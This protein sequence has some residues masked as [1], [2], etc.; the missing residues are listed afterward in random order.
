MLG[1]DDLAA[2]LKTDKEKT[3]SGGIGF[4]L[5]PIFFPVQRRGVDSLFTSESFNLSQAVSAGLWC[6]EH[7]HDIDPSIKY[8]RV[9]Q[10]DGHNWKLLEV[11]HSHVKKTKFFKPRPSLRESSKQ[12]VMFTSA[13]RF[14]DDYEHM[15]SVIGLLRFAM[16]ITENIV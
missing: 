3:D 4:P 5:V 12:K 16:G 13:A 7:M 8:A 6:L 15:L 14:M 10:T 1:V 11:H 9:I 2:D